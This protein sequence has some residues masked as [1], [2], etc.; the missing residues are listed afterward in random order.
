MDA[1]RG[2]QPSNHSVSGGLDQ[3]HSAG[4]GA[5]N[6]QYIGSD[7]QTPRCSD[8]LNPVLVTR[9][10]DGTLGG[11]SL[12]VANALAVHLG[13]PIQLKPY[14]NPARYND[15][16]RSR[17]MTGTLASLPAIPRALTISHSV[18]HLW[19]STTVTLQV[20]TLHRLAQR[21][22]TSPA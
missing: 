20:L 6:R 15:S 8:R 7:R 13:V 19:R 22:S 4:A 21:R 9:R 14:D 5:S 17:P 2:Y 18:R 11:V 10:P 1:E 16:L 3:Q 12:A